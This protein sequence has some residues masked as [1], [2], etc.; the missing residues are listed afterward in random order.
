MPCGVS[1]ALG[2]CWPQRAG[3]G[4]LTPTAAGAWDTVM[5]EFLLRGRTD[6]TAEPR[7]ACSSPS[8]SPSLLASFSPQP[9]SPKRATCH[10]F[11]CHVRKCR[12]TQWPAPSHRALTG[13]GLEGMVWAPTRP[14]LFSP[15]KDP[16][17]GGPVAWF[18]A[19][20][21][22]Q[23]RLCQEHRFPG[24]QE[25][26]GVPPQ[27]R[28][29]PTVTALWNN[30][31]RGGLPDSDWTPPPTAWG[32]RQG[33]AGQ[34]RSLPSPRL[35]GCRSGPSPADLGVFSALPHWVRLREIDSSC[36]NLEM[37]DTKTRNVSLLTSQNPAAEA[38]AR[39]LFLPGEL[40]TW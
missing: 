28:P 19:G 39:G 22:G 2:H 34:G 11:K 3:L 24:K 6:V 26:P 38:P 13:A 29:L 18:R 10:R 32:D 31:G 27:G 20:E 35:L 40:A 23:R 17:W 1:T 8:P 36:L 33:R 7:G 37:T 9:G 30:L 21:S 25:A 14:G 15:P 5:V 16:L 4:R 12:V